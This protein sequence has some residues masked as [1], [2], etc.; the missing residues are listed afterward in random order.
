MVIL[1]RK[2]ESLDKIEIELVKQGLTVIKHT[3]LSILDKSHVKDFLAF[4]TIIVND[5]SSIHWKRILAL[6]LGVNLAH[7][8]V[9]NSIN[10]RDSIKKL[11]DTQANYANYLKE[12]DSLYSSLKS[13]NLKDVDK[14]RYILL[15]L[16]K[17][18]TIK[19]KHDSHFED[20]IKDINL[21][22]SYLSNSNI[23][24]FINELY[25]NQS[26]E[27]NL[28]NSIYLTT[29]HGSKGLE[30]DFVY[31]I[32]VDSENFPSVK[33]NYFKLEGDEIEEERRLFYVACSRAKQNLIITYNYCYNPTNYYNMSPFIRELDSDLFNSIGMNFDYLPMTGNITTDINNHL[34]YIGFAKIYPLLKNVDCTRE[35]IHHQ[36]DLPKF[37]DKFKY[38]KTVIGNFFDF[39]IAKIVQINF[40]KSIKKFELSI[41]HRL[42]K[43]PQKIRQ[44]YNDELSDWRNLLEDI[45][46]ISIFNIKD[47]GNIFDDLKK[48]LINGESYKHYSNISDKLTKYINTFKPKEIFSHL[49]V[50]HAN[51]RGEIDLLVDETLFEIKTNQYEIA[52]TSNI[53]QTL[54]YGYLMQKKDKNVKNIILYNPI[55]GEITKLNTSNINF[56]E[57]ASIF[58]GHFKKSNN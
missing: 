16:E 13:N 2:N 28:D 55:S 46:Q 38:S 49:N 8:I 3:G 11:K 26:I 1:A 45:F 17:I 42:E 18:W 52:T 35:N 54:I 32:D 48:L 21:L 58:Y 53:S 36:F 56:K 33:T 22:L 27:I 20:K 44:N 4:L 41:V 25:L 23:H 15:F 47:E 40:T 24:Q 6:Q 7:E 39:L 9:E 30:W 57:V 34:K 31:L 12:I 43:F 14:G 37:F 29:I 10:I 50:S 19:N 5:K 51:I